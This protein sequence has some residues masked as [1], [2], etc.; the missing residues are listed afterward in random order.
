MRFSRAA[1][2]ASS[3]LSASFLA[4]APAQAADLPEPLWEA[5]IGG[6]AFSGPTYPGAD[7]STTQALFIPYVIY[8]G[9]VFS[10]GEESGVRAV[11]FA[12][13]KFEFDI[14]LGAS[15]AA[16]ASEDDDRDGMPDLE[17]LFEIGP[18]I[19]YHA[20]QYEHKS[21]TSHFDIKLRTRAIIATD[22]GSFEDQGYIVE[23]A[24]VYE[25]KSK[26]NRHLEIQLDIEMINGSE[27]LNEYFYDVDSRYAKPGREEYKAKAGYI[28]TEIGLGLSIPVNPQLRLF[29][30]FD[31]EF[32]DGSANRDSP[33][34]KDEMGYSGGLGLV[35]TFFESDERVPQR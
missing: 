22:L 16:D 2:L 28:G 11:A 4:G 23:P 17:F 1:F 5:G 7:D 20:A 24:F 35:Y 9:E 18:Q 25:L 34:F 33:L 13:E 30:G 32:Y 3:F 6:G 15:L 31:V 27:R 8:R 10:I 29:G 12:N 21:W 26:R 14:S 19:I